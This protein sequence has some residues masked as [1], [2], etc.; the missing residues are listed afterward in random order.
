MDRFLHP[1]NAGPLTAYQLL[2]PTTWTF[3][4]TILF[5]GGGALEAWELGEFC[6]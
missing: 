4:G 1:L 2:V 5:G 3:T 6:R